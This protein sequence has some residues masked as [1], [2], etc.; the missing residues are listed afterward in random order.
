MK[1]L[2]RLSS[3]PTTCHNNTNFKLSSKQIIE[4]WD[5]PNPSNPSQIGLVAICLEP[6]STIITYVQ[7]LQFL[8]HQD[9]SLE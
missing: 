7:Q 9:V 2:T 3:I 5:S 1:N 6:E 8:K 4:I